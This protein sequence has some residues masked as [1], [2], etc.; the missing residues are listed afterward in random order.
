MA[1]RCMSSLSK[2]PGR[3]LG[4]EL[5][6]TSRRDSSIGTQYI[7]PDGYAILASRVVNRRGA[8]VAATGVDG[9]EAEFSNA[10]V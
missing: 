2:S 3:Q 7:S 10:A 8:L 5:A 4:T 9:R 6:S 1:H